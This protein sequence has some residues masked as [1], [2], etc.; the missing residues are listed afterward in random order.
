MSRTTLYRYALQ[1]HHPFPPNWP[2]GRWAGQGSR[3]A[4]R[5]GCMAHWWF[6][7]GRG[8][9]V[10]QRALRFAFGPLSPFYSPRRGRAADARRGVRPRPGLVCAAK[11]RTASKSTRKTFCIALPSF[12]S[13]LFRCVPQR[14]AHSILRRTTNLVAGAALSGRRFGSVNISGCVTKLE[15]FHFSFMSIQVRC[16]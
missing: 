6:R 2:A 7:T 3:S 13:F 1:S 10:E 14:T 12:I 5:A 16:R 11:Y 4:P 8:G 15:A 9:H